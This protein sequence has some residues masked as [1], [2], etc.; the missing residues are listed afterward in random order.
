MNAWASTMLALTAVG[1]DT[2]RNVRCRTSPAQSAELASWAS[3]R[4]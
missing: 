2:A 1:T 4:L 3:V